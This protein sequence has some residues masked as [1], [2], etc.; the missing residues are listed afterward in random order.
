MGHVHIQNQNQNQEEHK[1]MPNSSITHKNK[2]Q[3]QSIIIPS[4]SSSLLAQQENNDFFSMLNLNSPSST[5]TRH[6]RRRNS[7]KRRALSSSSS[8]K[9]RSAK[10]HSSVQDNGFSAISLPISLCGNNAH[11]LRRCVS[12]LCQSLEQSTPMMTAKES[13]LPPLPPKL[14][15]CMSADVK[16]VSHSLNTEDNTPDSKRLKRMKDRLREMKQWWDDVMKEEEEEEGIEEEQEEK[17]ESPVAEEDKDLSQLQITIPQSPVAEDDKFISQDECGEDFE[18]AVSV[19]WAEKCLSLTFK[20]PCGKGNEETS[21]VEYPLQVDHNPAKNKAEFTSEI[22]TS[23]Q[24]MGS[25]LVAK[26]AEC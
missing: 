10:K 15:R 21:E 8:S 3:Q 16:S 6:Q 12:D 1:L 18:E 5:L 2:Q 7:A 11:V 14:T 23:I 26:K 24:S 13:G 25:L 19:E 22:G 9:Q 20:C 4:P 17:E